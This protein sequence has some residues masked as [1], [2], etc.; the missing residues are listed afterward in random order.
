MPPY[1]SGKPLDEPARRS[2]FGLGDLGTW[3]C[4]S[5]HHAGPRPTGEPRT[6]RRRLRVHHH[7][8]HVRTRGCHRRDKTANESD[9]LDPLLGWL[10]LRPQRGGKRIRRVR[11]ECQRWVATRRSSGGVVRVLALAPRR[12]PPLDAAVAP[13]P[14][15]TPAVTALARFLL[16]GH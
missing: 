15:W 4:L 1:G 9:R 3:T 12:P 11:R 7:H 13:V 16:V 6:G 10:H 8:P 2:P 14:R 5:C